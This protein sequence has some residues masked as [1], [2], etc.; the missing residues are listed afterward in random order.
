[1]KRLWFM[2][3][4]RARNSPS[5]LRQYGNLLVTYLGPQKVRVAVM[6]I[7]LLASIGLQ[8]LGPQVIRVFIDSVQNGRD[9]RVLTFT[10]L[11]F[12]V[13]A[14]GSRLVSALASYV[15]EDVG[16]NATNRLRADLAAHCLQL[17]R[18]FHS[19][20]TPGELIERVDGDVDALA[21]FFSQFVISVVGNGLLS[22]GI[23]VLLAIENVW[24]GV[25]ML[26][27]LAVAAFAA[28]RI[29]VVAKPTFHARRQTDAEMS[30]F[31]GE[32][33]GAL[34]DI[35]SS[36]AVQYVL[37]RYFLLQRLSNK[38]HIRSSFFWA[39]YENV[40][41][42]IDLV[43]TLLILVMG[44][45]FFVHGTLTIGGVVLLLVYLE[46]LIYN[47]G[48]VSDQFGTLQEAT[49]SLERI[50]ELYHIT[51][52]VQDGPGVVFPSGAL[53][54][55]FQHVDFSYEPG[56]Q[57][58]SN[59]SFTIKAGE[60]VGL[61][62][63]TGSGK[64]TIT[65]LLLRFY[66]PDSGIVRLGEQDIR[67]SRLDDLHSRIGVVTQDVQLFQGTLRDNLTFFDETISDERILQ[68]IERLG[69]NEWFAHLPQRL[70]TQL[71]GNNGLSAGEAQLLACVRVF[72]RTPQLIIFDEASSRLDPVTETLMTHATQR[73][74][75]H[76]TGVIIAHHLATVQR[77]DNILIL[78]NGRIVEFGRREQLVNNPNSHYAQ[79]LK[80]AHSKELLA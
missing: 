32:V 11:L 37:R 79:L 8:L 59:I 76:C 52:K 75:E 78:E 34:E 16:W 20:H 14:I 40:W 35:A 50:N 67:Q 74:L 23:L 41:V 49:T 28:T 46:Q 3:S 25:V 64:T 43:G 55:E 22:L 58:L 38:A 56:Q 51:S 1:M 36:G 6:V 29:Q 24:I 15:S 77:V 44:A 63:R 17:D 62:G 4:F 33:L 65:R 70:D 47:T 73:L 80:M 2:R 66:D 72:L 21:N 7:L 39:A 26:L 30:G 12:L 54:I 61:I 9:V 45:Y 69:I 68:A 13:V 48:E 19:S 53:S 71:S 27:Y 42:M 18:S 10:A 57:V 60:I 31:F 5:Q